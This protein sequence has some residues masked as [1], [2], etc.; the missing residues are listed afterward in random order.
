MDVNE[1]EV[2][3]YRSLAEMTGEFQ[4]EPVPEYTNYNPSTNYTGYYTDDS[5]IGDHTYF[6]GVDYESSRPNNYRLDIMP[7]LMNSYTQD[8]TDTDYGSSYDLAFYDGPKSSTD[9]GTFGKAVYDVK[10]ISMTKLMSEINPDNAYNRIYLS[11]IDNLDDLVNLP[12]QNTSIDWCLFVCKSKTVHPVI[13][14]EY[15]VVTEYVQQ[16]GGQEIREYTN[17]VAIAA[18]VDLDT[19]LVTFYEDNDFRTQVAIYPMKDVIIFFG[20]TNVVPIPVSTKLMELGTDLYV[21]L[22]KV[23]DPEYMD[24][25]YG[26]ELL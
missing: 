7:E 24:P 26:V 17:P 5:V 13:R 15:V 16:Q 2:T 4:S 9:S 11:S 10:N 3:K 18:M 14:N 1:D 21:D 22:R 25:S 12:G 6:G 23:G 19:K 20:G 8:M